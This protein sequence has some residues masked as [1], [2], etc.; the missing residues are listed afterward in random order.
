MVNKFGKE[1]VTPHATGS[2]THRELLAPSRPSLASG[3]PSLLH[4][5]RQALSWDSH[6]FTSHA[7]IY[8]FPMQSA[9]PSAPT[10]LFHVARVPAE[11]ALGGP[12]DAVQDAAINMPRVLAAADHVEERRLAC[13]RSGAQSCQH[14]WGGIG[15]FWLRLGSENAPVARQCAQ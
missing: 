14:P 5:K 3:S 1:V 13:T 2:R 9:L 4:V 11:E 15:H 8:S 12:A 6:A 10:E 7:V